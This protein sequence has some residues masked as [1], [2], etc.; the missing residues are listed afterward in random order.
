M[1]RNTIFAPMAPEPKPK[2]QQQPQATNKFL[3]V[4]A[5]KATATAS[6]RS[7]TTA[8][9]SSSSSSSGSSSPVTRKK[10]VTRARSQTEWSAQPQFPKK[11]PQSVQQNNPSVFSCVCA[12]TLYRE[13]DAKAIN[14]FV[15]KK[16]S[17]GQSPLKLVGDS[18]G[19][20][21]I[22]IRFD[23]MVIASRKADGIE[24][25]KEKTYKIKVK[26]SVNSFLSALVKRENLLRVDFY[27]LCDCDTMEVISGSTHFIEIIGG[28][29]PKPKFLLR[30]SGDLGPDSA[31]TAKD[32]KH[33]SANSAKKRL[34]YPLL[35]GT[36]SNS[37]A[38]LME[39]HNRVSVTMPGLHWI[40][41]LAEK[42]VYG[43]FVSTG[44]T[45]SLYSEPASVFLPPR[46]EGDMTMHPVPAVIFRDTS[47]S[48][49]YGKRG[50]VVWCHGL[51]E[52]LHSSSPKIQ[53]Y[54][55]AARVDIISPEYL[56]FGVRKDEALWHRKTVTCKD[57][58]NDIAVAVRHAMDMWDDVPYILFGRGEGADLALNFAL[59]LYG[60][61]GPT[62]WQT[63]AA[64]SLLGL[65]VVEDPSFCKETV[66]YVT[67]LGDMLDVPVLFC[68]SPEY[69][70]ADSSFLSWFSLK[71]KCAYCIKGNSD[72]K[73]GWPLEKGMELMSSIVDI[74][75]VRKK[76][77]SAVPDVPSDAAQIPFY[78]PP[79]S[80]TNTSTL[81]QD[82]FAF[83]RWLKNR[84]HDQMAVEMFIGSGVRT[85]G[86]LAAMDPVA[87][88]HPGKL[89][90]LYMKALSEEAIMGM[91]LTAQPWD[92]LKKKFLYRF[93]TCS[94][95]TRS[96]RVPVSQVPSSWKVKSDDVRDDVNAEIERDSENVPPGM[97]KINKK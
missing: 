66:S 42:R 69:S 56:G 82:V 57:L 86:G 63:E 51:D 31:Y 88:T 39:E 18:M 76:L 93:K 38:F 9:Q 15:A 84:G 5:P 68:S 91:E 28:S 32:A 24:I 16:V 50:V 70:T 37:T 23:K 81:K 60:K 8:T 40:P 96:M 53:A 71:L 83:R 29:N 22:R 79:E 17:T 61:S 36:M 19:Q 62:D 72:S 73:R 59:S 25:P 14:K 78:Q 45:H 48:I 90:S 95:R 46:I 10:V 33:D 21:T 41:G 52:D 92:Q 65:V 35:P 89:K 2:K 97:T 47:T 80:G 3:P 20:C 34:F 43:G 85:I 74:K 58:L 4:I 67:R 12:F 44:I 1:R 75:K 54:S 49:M 64:R 77:H 30:L 55:A 7:T 26:K 94:P 27:E 87:H 13:K 11:G 6:I